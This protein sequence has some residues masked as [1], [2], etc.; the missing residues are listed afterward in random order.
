MNAQNFMKFSALRLKKNED[1]RVR[2]GHAWIFSNEVDTAHTPLDSFGAGDFVLVEDSRG[3]VLGIAYVNPATLICA[4]LLTRNLQCPIDQAFLRTRVESALRLRKRLFQQPFY[5]LVFGESDAL[6]GLVIDRFGDVLVV[7]IST[8]GME[9]LKESLLAALEELLA[10][11]AIVLKN[12]SPMRQLEGLSIYTEVAKGSIDAPIEIEE[13]GVRFIVDPIQGQ[14]TGWFY[15]QR[16]NRALTAMLS[17]GQRVLDLFSYTGGWGIQAAMAGAETVDCVDSSES[18]VRQAAENARLNGVE[19]RIRCLR[20]DALEFLKR[21][22]QE[23]R[24]YDLVILD[25]PALIQRKKDASAGTEAYHRLNQLALQVLSREGILVAA[26]CSYHLHRDTLQQILRAAA[27]HADRSL[28][29]LASGGQA[30]DHPIH[31]AIAETE[32]L[33]VFW[34]W[35]A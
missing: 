19:R 29:F 20:D 22:R 21:A 14:K 18:A 9:R 3:H 10:P 16:N 7:Q 23:R 4:R 6:P 17:K 1:R 2:Q 8:A 26:S 31:P 27:R 34:C 33:K 25:P 28:V 13:N 30:L 15:D 5:R 12:N 32:Y 24:R 35:A 11:R